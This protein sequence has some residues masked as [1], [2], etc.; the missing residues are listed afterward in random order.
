MTDMLD[1]MTYDI[2]VGELP[3]D[4]N[5]QGEPQPSHQPLQSWNV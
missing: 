5:L 3:K 1:L 4:N 2:S